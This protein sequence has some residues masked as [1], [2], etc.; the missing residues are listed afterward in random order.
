MSSGGEDGAGR[1]LHGLRACRPAG[2]G[3]EGF[4]LEKQCQSGGAVGP[5]L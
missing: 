4:R 2:R 1:H 3:S 5:V